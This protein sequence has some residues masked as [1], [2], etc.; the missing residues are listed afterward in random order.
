M[1]TELIAIVDD[2]QD[3]VELV[4]IHLKKHNF[5]VKTFYNGQ[6]FVDFLKTTKPGLVILDLMLPDIDGLQIC[7]SMRNNNE[8]KNI[9]IIMLTAKGDETDKIVGLELGADDYVTKPFSPKEL[10]ARVKA[11]L[12]RGQPEEKAAD[13]IDIAGRLVIDNKRFEVLVD[14]K[15]A[16]LT[17]TEFRILMILASRQGWVFSREQLLNYLWG[18][19]KAV[20]DRTIDVHIKHLREKLGTAGE[21][22]K[23]IRGIGYKLDVE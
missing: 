20:L 17:T 21:L 13:V 8:F 9:P 10:V 2:E 15:P 1:R 11:I 6:D 19:E 7:T 5:S 3:I 4:S 22:V 16:V 14:G 18:N 23:N 12:R